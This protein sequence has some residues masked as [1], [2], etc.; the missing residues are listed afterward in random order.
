MMKTSMQDHF[1]DR[2]ECCSQLSFRN[3]KKAW[4]R[5]FKKKF[6]Y[7]IKYLCFMDSKWLKKF[8]YVCV[9]PK[10]ILKCVST[11]LSIYTMLHK[12][13]WMGQI[14]P[15]KERKDRSQPDAPAHRLLAHQVFT[16][17]TRPLGKAQCLVSNSYCWHSSR[18]GLWCGS[19]ARQRTTGRERLNRRSKKVFRNGQLLSLWVQ[20]KPQL[21]IESVP[22]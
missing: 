11:S 2:S 6:A 3:T 22:P 1:K 9:S 14:H 19:T 17:L 5:Y 10:R 12:A 18:K 8:V 16:L 13:S 4:K 20:A 21:V 15:N 7:K